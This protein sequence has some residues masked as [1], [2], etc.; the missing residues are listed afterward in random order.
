MEKSDYISACDALRRHDFDTAFCVV[1]GALYENPDDP[2][3]LCLAGIAYTETGDQAAAI[4]AVERHLAIG[5]RAPE[6]YEALGCAYLRLDRAEDA[7]AAL[8]RAAD[9]DPGAA[10]VWRNLGVA[11][12]RLC[13]NAEARAA[14]QRSAARNPHDEL[15]RH[16]LRGLGPRGDGEKQ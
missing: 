3:A 9:L 4:R 10:S 8:E 13:R 12:S 14:L 1:L 11:Y 2:H 5:G 6:A 16:A 7:R 15:T